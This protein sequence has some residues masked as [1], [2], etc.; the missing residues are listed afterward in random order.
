MNDFTQRPLT[1]ADASAFAALTEATSKADRSSHRADEAAFRYHLNHPL[2]AQGAGFEDFQGVFDERQRLVAMAW[3][4]RQ[5]SAEP[6]HWMQSDGCVHPDFRGRG[7][8]TEL[9]RWQKDLAPRIHEHFFPG[10]PLDLFARL[11]ELNTEARD[12]FANEGFTPIRWTFEMQRPAD[13]PE[14]DRELPQDLDLEPY[15]P[16]VA[17]ELRVAH[18]EIFREHFRATPWPAD[19]WQAWL[20]QDKVRRDLSFLLRDP[21]NGA[22]AGYVVCSHVPTAAENGQAG[23][24]DGQ[25]AANRD[26]H[27]NIVGTNADYRGRGLAS[28][29]IAHVVRTARKEGF[30]TQS[31]GV[32]A[33][34]STGALGVYE[35][36]GFV[37]ERKYVYYNLK[38]EA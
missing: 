34:N 18:N 29:L 25:A 23:A 32:D 14:P 2:S 24:E 27:L 8:G 26:L 3:V 5:S 11:P 10:R 4:Q 28:A 12:L 37:V 36:S 6:A 17:E 33:E 7:I 22:I 38:F 16:A 35:R 13:A 1:D 20:A 30:A 9:V 31:L 15:T 19:A 21:S